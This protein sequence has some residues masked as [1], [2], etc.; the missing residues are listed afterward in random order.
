MNT[1]NTLSVLLWIYLGSAILCLLI[2][3]YVLRAAK[4]KTDYKARK[5]VSRVLSTVPFINTIFLLGI[6]A[7]IIYSFFNKKWIRD[8]QA[9]QASYREMPTGIA[10]N[11][12]DQDLSAVDRQIIEHVK[13]IAPD[14]WKA[15]NPSGYWCFI[16]GHGSDLFRID[17]AAWSNGGEKLYNCRLIFTISHQ[18]IDI[19]TSLLNDLFLQLRQIENKEGQLKVQEHLNKIETLKTQLLSTLSKSKQ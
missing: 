19:R 12:D 2:S 7:I 18:Q 14:K 17:A 10:G 15:A 8:A 6:V 13:K 5:V 4:D 16:P 1:Y 9:F 3:D 11:P